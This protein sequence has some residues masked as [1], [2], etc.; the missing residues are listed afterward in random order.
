MVF[1]ES[2]SSPKLK[3][4][5]TA[6][7][8]SASNS[9]SDSEPELNADQNQTQNRNPNPTRN[10]TRNECYSRKMLKIITIIT[11]EAESIIIFETSLELTPRTTT[12]TIDRFRFR[13]TVGTKQNDA[14]V[15]NPISNGSSNSNAIYNQ[16]LVQNPI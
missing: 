10:R 8:V 9:N 6:K 14:R 16:T 11:I 15:Q 12:R 4:N 3:W 5:S 1:S 2:P 13:I 7:S